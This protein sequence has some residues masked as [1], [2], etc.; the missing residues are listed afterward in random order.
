MF[1]VLIVEDDLFFAKELKRD[2]E[3]FNCPN[4]AIASTVKQAIQFFK[5]ISPEL[6]FI[7]IELGDNSNGVTF[8]E[9]INK[10][11]R[12]PFIFLTNFYGA[13]QKHFRKANNTRPSNFL[14]KGSFLPKQL[15]HFVETAM[16]NFAIENNL[17][18]DGMEKSFFLQ[19]QIFIKDKNRFK[20]ILAPEI[21]YIEV[22][23][24]YCK[25]YTIDRI[26]APKIT[27]EKLLL[28]LRNSFIVRCHQSFAV[29]VNYIK[30]HAPS[31]NELILD[32]GK[33]LSIGRKYKTDLL[34][35][36][37]LIKVKTI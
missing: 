2:L 32:T 24:A 9:F 16:D 11:K 30:E 18:I 26:Y 25:I 20:R 21:R 31:T 15:W 7:D 8:A 23:D 37:T 34:K 5:S 12:V 35:R 17:F 33:V 4:V 10:T 28:S 13:D 36:I 27:L 6:V 22:A 1:N 3:N 14:P 19:G 29:N